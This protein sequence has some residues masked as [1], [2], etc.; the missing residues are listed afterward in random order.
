MAGDTFKMV[1]SVIMPSSINQ[2][3]MALS[4][5]MVDL[6]IMMQRARQLPCMLSTLFQFL[7]PH[8]VF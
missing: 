3:V 4:P 1:I 6:K 7:T 5:D 8:K 2:Y